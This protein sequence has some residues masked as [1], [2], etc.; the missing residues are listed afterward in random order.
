MS[1][2]I[3][4]KFRSQHLKVLEADVVWKL[5]QWVIGLKAIP[6]VVPLKKAEKA[7]CWIGGT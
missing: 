7:A 4:E 2:K 1:F 3:Q 6:F 5:N